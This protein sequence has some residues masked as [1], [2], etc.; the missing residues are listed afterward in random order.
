M[1]HTMLRA[2]LNFISVEMLSCWHMIHGQYARGYLS[3]YTHITQSVNT[4]CFQ[5]GSFQKGNS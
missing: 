5:K 3:L 1:Q 2:N 4:E